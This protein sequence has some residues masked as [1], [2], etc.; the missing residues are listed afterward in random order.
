MHLSFQ[1]N[2]G[3]TDRVIRIS[4]GVIMIVLAF[5]DPWAW[6]GWKKQRYRIF[7]SGNDHRR[8]H[9]LLTLL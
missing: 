1:R 6:A 3:K 8:D 9:E 7:G 2:I 4:I 5:F